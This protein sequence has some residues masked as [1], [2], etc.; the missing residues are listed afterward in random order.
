MSEPRVSLY[1]VVDPGTVPIAP[2]FG[3]VRLDHMTVAYGVPLDDALLALH[4][5]AVTLRATAICRGDGC[6]ALAVDLDGSDPGLAAAFDRFKAEGAWGGERLPHV[7]VSLRPGVSP[8]AAMA[9]VAAPGERVA[10]DFPIAGRVEALVHGRR[11]EIGGAV[12]RSVDDYNADLAAARRLDE[13]AAAPPPPPSGNERVD[14]VAAAL[15]AAAAAHAAWVI[16]GAP[17]PD[18]HR[19]AAG[20]LAALGEAATPEKTRQA[21]LSIEICGDAQVNWY[22]G[23][24]RKPKFDKGARLLLRNL[25]RAGEDVGQGA[26]F[27]PAP[28]A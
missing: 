20:L 14:A 10:V 23:R 4:G 24:G 7:T 28:E 12:L 1:V 2:S 11:L 13:A 19:A 17:K 26:G 18:P 22:Y 5:R 15:E 9:V 3:D 6:E 8:G 27:R 16:R 25:W 21:L